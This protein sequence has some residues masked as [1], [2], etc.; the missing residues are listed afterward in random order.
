M[1]RLALFLLLSTSLAAAE[2]ERGK[3]VEN[4]AARSDATQTYT[5]YLPTSYDAA[6]VQPLLFV[7][8]PRGR[9][10]V[11]AEIFRD[12]AEEFGW[13]L[14]SSNQTRSDDDG[15]ASNRAVRALL[16]EINR[17]AIDPKRIYA[18]G[19]SGTAILSCAVGLK[20]NAFAGVIG[21]GGRLVDEFPPAKFPFAHYGLA[22]DTD[23]NNRE[24][25]NIDAILE[26]EGKVAH[27]FQQFEGNHRWCSASLAREAVAWM[28]LLAMKDGR[29]RR[30]AALIDKLYAE[31]IS[32][33]QALEASGKRVEAL[34]RNREIAKTFDGLHAIDEANAAV[35]RLQAD[36]ALQRE[37]KELARWDDFESLYMRQVFGTIPSTIARLREEDISPTASVLMREL[38]VPDLQRRAKRDGIEGVTARRLLEALYTHTSFYMMRDLMARHDYSLAAAVLGVATQIHGDRWPAWYN[39][40]AAQARAGDRRRALESLEKAASVGFRDRTQLATDEDFVSLREEARFRALLVQ[41]SQ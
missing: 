2:P 21:V 39:L 15:S 30:D 32:A 19:F 25:R 31:D 37:Q 36:A 22:G 14:I 4:I 26:R 6:R 35:A 3:L 18:A 16:P 38:R 23:F 17:Y 27:R 11:A 28:E 1:R 34:R 8:D 41:S 33:A 13:I 29:R 12:A 20:T 5:L 40:G 24:M 10:T 7:F 9:G